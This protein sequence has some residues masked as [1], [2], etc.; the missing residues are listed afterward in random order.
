MSEGKWKKMG[1]IRLEQYDCRG[2]EKKIALNR[3]RRAEQEEQSAVRRE[4]RS[5][6]ECRKQYTNIRIK[7]SK[8]IRVDKS[9]RK[10]R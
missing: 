3:G 1:R 8:Q 4:G 6:V 9:E 2:A 7:R 10:I 5:G